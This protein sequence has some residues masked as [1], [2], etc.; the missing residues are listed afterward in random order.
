[1]ILA[2]SILRRPSKVVRV[3]REMECGHAMA[4]LYDQRDLP[5]RVQIKAKDLTT[6]GAPQEIL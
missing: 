3:Q 4:M 6:S 1:M 2:L 5:S